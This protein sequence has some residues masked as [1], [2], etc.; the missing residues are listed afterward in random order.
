MKNLKRFFN[1]KIDRE[2]G[3]I[4]DTFEDRIKNA[5]LNAIDSI[6][7][8]KIELAVKSFTASLEQD[9]TSD[10]VNS[11]RGER[12]GFIPLFENV[13]ERN[14]TLHELNTNDETRNNIPDE[15]SE[16]SVP[17]T[18]FDQQSHTHHS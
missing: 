13:S 11:E 4:V 6:I 16:L 2:V 1:E 15:V 17:E 18:H 9:A 5:I 7:A 14:N 12:V 8:P 10:T 3:N